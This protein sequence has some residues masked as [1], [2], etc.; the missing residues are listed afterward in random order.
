MNAVRHWAAALIVLAVAGPVAAQGVVINPRGA[1]DSATTTRG[2]QPKKP[3]QPVVKVALGA[4]P[5]NFDDPSELKDANSQLAFAGMGKPDA[6]KKALTKAVEK[7]SLRPDHYSKNMTGYE[8]L[9]G[10]ALVSWSQYPG[11]APVVKR[12]EIGFL[13]DKDQ[14][15][16]LLKVADSAFS[17]VEKAQPTCAGETG[18]QR[19]RA[20]AP[21]IRS[22]P[23]LLNADKLDSAWMMLEK[24]NVI[25]RDSPYS[26]YFAAQILY[27]KD[28]YAK[29]SVQYE[30]TVNMATPML[31]ADTGL[32]GMAS[33]AAFLAPYTGARA[34]ATMTGADQVAAYKRV[35]TLYSAYL[36]EYP[37]AQYAENAA[38]GLFDALEAIGDSAGVRTRLTQMVAETKPCSDIWW[39]TAAREASE[40]NMMD[41]AVQLADKALAYSPWSAGLGNAAGAYYKVKDGAK[42]LP[43]AKRLVEVAPNL[44]DNY[45][46]EASAYQQLAEKA[47]VPA[48]KQAYKDSLV[49]V[50][51]KG[52]K[53][54]VKVRVS[55]FTSDRDN[56]TIG[57]TLELVNE[58]APPA[59]R[60]KGAKGVKP[61]PAPPAGPKPKA[62]QVTLTVQFLDRAGTPVSFPDSSGA[63]VTSLS[64]TFSVEPDKP[65]SFSLTAADPKIVG[66]KYGPIP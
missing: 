45:E 28:D 8:F 44:P 56:R 46:L 61:A 19:K 63:K 31:V 55:Q 51:T 25:Y 41:L 34:A 53:L 43:V 59:P 35:A 54:E 21:L 11:Q 9:L 42:L 65:T 60:P 30:N 1:I 38:S 18:D 32:I 40:Q 64:K 3:N 4:C 7:L 12:G 20:W 48:V 37:C 26:P 36:K 33:N 50:Y 58:Q 29:A 10:Q 49:T 47:T 13:G 22:V 6:Q 66:Y 27:K 57:G 2:P 16:D 39:Y 14:P 15:I 62:R 17:I 52:T 24:A 5:L 23:P